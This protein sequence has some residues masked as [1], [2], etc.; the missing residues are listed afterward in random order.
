MVN[1]VIGAI[2]R[3][4]PDFSADILT[5]ANNGDRIELLG[6]IT[7]E[8]GSR[9]FQVS[10]GPDQIGWLLASLVQTQTPAP[11]ETE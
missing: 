9:W 8:D 7:R 2:I 5:Y 4:D 3:Q 10:T 1:S 11:T 6:E